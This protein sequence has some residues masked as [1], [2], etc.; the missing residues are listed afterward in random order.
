MEIPSMRGSVNVKWIEHDDFK[1][2]EK[3]IKEYIDFIKKYYE[4]ILCFNKLKD[5]VV[6]TVDD[7]NGEVKPKTI[8]FY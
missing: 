2:E 4:F 7:I 3:I 6:E 5:T 8:L 1:I